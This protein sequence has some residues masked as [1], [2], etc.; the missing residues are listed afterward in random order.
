M[1]IVHNST[2][3]ITTQS[4]VGI[5]FR[6]IFFPVDEGLKILTANQNPLNLKELDLKWQMKKL[7]HALIINRTYCP[8]LCTLK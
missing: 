3:T 7:Q 6:M 5:T 8:L 1:R 2:I 4:I